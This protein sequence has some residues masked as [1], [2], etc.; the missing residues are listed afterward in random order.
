ME[1]HFLFDVVLQDAVTVLTDTQLQAQD[2]RCEDCLVGIPTFI[3]SD[4]TVDVT[5]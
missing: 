3:T 5:D 1:I 4:L 2:I